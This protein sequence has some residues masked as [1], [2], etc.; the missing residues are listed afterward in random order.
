MKHLTFKIFAASL[1]LAGAVSVSA[2]T[3]QSKDEI[4]E[5]ARKALETAAQQAYDQSARGDTQGLQAS[6]IPSLQSNFSGMGSR[7]S[8]SAI[9][10]TLPLR[11]AMTVSSRP[12]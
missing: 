3:C 8:K 7:R 9:R 12:R 4:A 5:P 1:V 10:M 6:A 2:Q 11:I